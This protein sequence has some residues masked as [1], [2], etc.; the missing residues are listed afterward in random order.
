MTTATRRS[1]AA[2]GALVIMGLV[3][4]VALPVHAGT[5]ALTTPTVTAPSVTA[6]SVTT[7]T[8]PTTTTSTCGSQLKLVKSALK[9]APVGAAKDQAKTHYDNAVAANK[10][11]DD[12]KCLS[13]LDAASALLK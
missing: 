4:A 12:K 2:L 10:S 5:P 7:P 3:G 6:P 1:G 11:H 13:E 9:K 8:V